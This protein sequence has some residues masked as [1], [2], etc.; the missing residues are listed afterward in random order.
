MSIAT[1]TEVKTYLRYPNPTGSSPD[2]TMIQ[3]F[4]NSADAV[5]NRVCGEVDGATYDEWYPGGDTVIQLR[6][7][8]VQT[9]TLV[10]ENWGFVTYTLT[11][12]PGD[13][14]PSLTSLWAYSL[15]LPLSGLI[16]RR[17][18]GNVVV[19]FVNASGGGDNVRI[20]YTT[21]VAVIAGNIKHAYMDLVAHWW[22]NSQQRTLPGGVSA[23]SYDAVDTSSGYSAG[24][25][26]RIMEILT[27]A[28]RGPIIG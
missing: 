16:T 14:D 7:F 25:P 12:Q 26:Y 24:V 5:I 2:D 21:G 27:G 9:I 28:R 17:S 6:H 20:Q 22:Q 4:M 8:P 1:L 11:A 15:D 13:T 10:E 23:E 19:P 3:D 18:V